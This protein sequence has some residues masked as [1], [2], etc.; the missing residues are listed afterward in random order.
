MEY[1]MKCGCKVKVTDDTL[2]ATILYCPKHKAAE[3]MYEA[4]KEI[5]LYKYLTDTN[6]GNRIKQALAKAESI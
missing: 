3:D 1:M 4:L 2:G 6:T 5:S